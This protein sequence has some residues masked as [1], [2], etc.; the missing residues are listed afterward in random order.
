MARRSTKSRKNKKSPF[1]GSLLLILTG[2]LAALALVAWW[3]IT[4]PFGPQA[5]TFVEIA[6]GSST[7]RIGAQLEQAGIIRSQYAFELV[8]LIQRGRLQA[9][10]YRF[11]RPANVSEVYRRI[12]HGDVY[13]RPLTI[14]E[15]ANIYDIAARVEQAHLASSVD[16]LAAAH[17]TQ[18]IADLDP[19]ARS[20]EGY[21]FPDTYR[22]AHNTTVPQ[23]VA[24]MVH[25]FRQAAA[26]AGIEGDFHSVVTLAS[27]VERETALESERPLVAS[28]FTNRLAQHMPLA[29][30]PSVI[31]G[32]LTEGRWTG[33]IHRS[34]LAHD[35]P[36][37]T[38][39]HAGL[40]PGPIANPGL[41]SLKAAANPAKTSYL[42]FVAAGTNAQGHSLFATTLDEHNHNVAGYRRA[43]KKAGLR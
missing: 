20:L 22:F 13:T 28:V 5:E 40:P 34:D 15:G 18:L 17:Q 29:T 33:V 6:P 14:P 10:E 23:M 36:Y 16:F 27:V 4:S 1:W 25:R 11:S 37:N 42:Y 3:M 2:A 9:G 21:L 43:Q 41:P 7:A 39:L 31:Y 8:R 30:D 32:L 24:A 35:T 19:N 12:V 26:Q 38:Y